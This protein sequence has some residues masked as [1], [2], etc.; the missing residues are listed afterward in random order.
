LDREH[1]VLAY[2]YALVFAVL[3]SAF[4]DE[5]YRAVL[6]HSDSEALKGSVPNEDR[7]CLLHLMVLVKKL[8]RDLGF[9]FASDGMCRSGIALA[10]GLRCLACK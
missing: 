3:D 2:R 5:R 7:L 1:G 9:H 6:G 8:L 10:A 4:G